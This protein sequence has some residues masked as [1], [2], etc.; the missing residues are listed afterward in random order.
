MNALN[1]NDFT[2]KAPQ[3]SEQRFSQ[4]V[5]NVPG[6]IYQFVQRVDGSRFFPYVSFGCREII[7]LEPETIQDNVDLVLDMIHPDDRQAFED[8]VARSWQTLE[9]WYWEGRVTIPS[10]KVKW[11][12]G[13]SRPQLQMNGDIIW[14]GLLMDI[15]E[16]KQTLEALRESEERFRQLVENISEVFWM[17]S[18]DR[19][20]MIYVSPVYEKIWGKSC[21]SLYQ[22]PRSWIDTVHPE[23][24]DCL[25]ASIEKLSTQEYDAEYRIVRSDGSIRWIRDRG[26]P[27][28]DAQGRAYRRAGVATDI[29]SHKQAELE[30]DKAL[31]RER[32]LGELKSRFV[33]MTSHEFRTPLSTIQSSAELLERYRDKLSQEK[34]LTHLQRIQMAVDRMAQML[35][36][37]LI[38]GEAE[39]GKLKFNS[40]PLDLRQ[41]CC[42]LVEELQQGSGKQHAIAFTSQCPDIHYNIDAKLLRH[43]L[44]N[45]LS[46][47]IKYSPKGTIIQF[48]LSCCDYKATFR[49]RDRGMG[50]PPEDL[51]H[52]FE[53]FHRA[54]NVG[55]IQGTGLGLAI[56]KQCVDLHQGE[57]AVT[58]EVGKGTTFT[59]ILPLNKQVA[60]S[61]TN[62]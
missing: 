4:L 56:V 39:A 38:I 41:F 10:G 57:I 16:R 12:Q 3:E 46:N 47:A 5:A 7:E 24:R 49:I 48:D 34:Q 1:L 20:E 53:S 25:L 17:I 60:L 26:Y 33:A 6:M 18:L 32:E 43:I 61:A 50:I 30:S 55:A 14:D 45:L 29:T 35:N 19:P 23:D 22:Q 36:D 37:I 31:Q 44:S 52:L 40:A 58:S 15:T 11:L 28:Y 13:A 59:V 8:S 62:A 2:L 42:D 27:V 21:E 9:P 54:K 51:R